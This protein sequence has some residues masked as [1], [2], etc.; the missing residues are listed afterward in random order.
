VETLFSRRAQPG[1]LAGQRRVDFVHDRGRR[2]GHNAW[3]GF[4][5]FRDGRHVPQLDRI[6][7]SGGVGD[8]ARAKPEQAQTGKELSEIH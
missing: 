1:F 7:S 4:D 8:E 5:I 2:P 3:K 6:F